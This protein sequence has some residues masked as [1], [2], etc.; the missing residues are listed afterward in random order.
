MA[1]H[2]L[3]KI[4]CGGKSLIE[5]FSKKLLAEVRICT[6]S[7]DSDLVI[8]TWVLKLAPSIGSVIPFQWMYP[9]KIETQK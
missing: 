7:V 5:V 2:F 8:F 4:F 3:K 9:K 1:K 6:N